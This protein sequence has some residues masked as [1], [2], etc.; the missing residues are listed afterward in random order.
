V[1][2]LILIVWV[3]HAFAQTSSSR[4]PLGA[5]DFLEYWAAGRLLLYGGNPYSP[6]E[7]FQLQKEAGWTDSV[8]VIMWN[9]PWTLLITAP[10]GAFS[11]TTG[12]FFWLLFQVALIFFSVQQLWRIY[13]G[14]GASRF[15][16]VL[17]V[18]FV[19]T[20]F[21]FISGQIS[22]VVL[23]GLTG[24]LYFQQRK[25]F[26]AAG[27]SAALLTVK[28]HLLYLFWI[29]FA[30]WV[31]RERQ[32]RIL[33]GV[34]VLGCSLATI[35]LLF[36][37]QVYSQY[38]ALYK[39]GDIP[40]P[41]DWLTPTLRTATRVFIGPGHLWLQSAPSIAGV[42]WILFHWYR[43]K[44][45]WEWLDQLPGVVLVSVVTSFFAWTYDQVVFFPAIVA[46]AIW[47]RQQ[48]TDWHNF[49]S[50]RIYIFINFCHAVLRIWVADEVWYYWLAPSL[51]LTYVIFLWE[52]QPS[53]AAEAL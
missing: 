43:H 36:D 15:V 48:S 40:R 17:P 26:F 27:G 13:G 32:W 20:T 41:L 30:L 11:Y 2:W 51:L 37:S 12:Q 44:G 49:W 52:K 42:V 35:P 10:F 4:V 21:A 19:S 31:W 5:K 8:P 45:Q 39:I 24:F 6:E 18:T 50:V 47:I 14:A 29:V 23:A 16:W 38:V 25:N 3:H 53:R 1:I 34:L 7:L 46:A 22:P 33:S 9:P 28:P